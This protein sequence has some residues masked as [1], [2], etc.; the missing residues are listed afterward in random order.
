MTNHPPL[1]KA[2]LSGNGAS[3]Q[4]LFSIHESTYE[5]IM[6][7][8]ISWV[9][10]AFLSRLLSDSYNLKRSIDRNGPSRVTM[11]P[12]QTAG[13]VEYDAVIL[14]PGIFWWIFKNRYNCACKGG[15]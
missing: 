9:F 4:D 14:K 7:G 6:Q 8:F 13:A 15:S 11:G 1:E 3:V 12:L 2:W 5:L 10:T